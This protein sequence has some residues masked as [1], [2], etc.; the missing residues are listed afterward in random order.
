MAT[1]GDAVGEETPFAYTDARGTVRATVVGGRHRAR[2][3]VGERVRAVVERIVPGTNRV[4]LS[5]REAGGRELAEAQA[6]WLQRGGHAEED[7]KEGADDALAVPLFAPG[8]EV[9]GTVVGLGERGLVVAR[10]AP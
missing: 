8:D 3:A 6:G 4:V 1:P 5:V 10:T 7:D 9:W 2:A